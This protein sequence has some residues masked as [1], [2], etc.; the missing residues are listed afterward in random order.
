M[1]H[2]DLASH[3]R[4]AAPI[5]QVWDR[6]ADP[7]GWPRWW[8]GM[9][10]VQTLRPP[11]AQGLGGRHRVEWAG[12]WPR[13]AAVEIEAIESLPFQRLRGRTRGALAGE[14]IW[15]LRAHGHVTEVTGLWR[16]EWINP[17]LR[18][19]APLLAHLVRWNH[20]GLMRAGAQ[21]LARHLRVAEVIQ[22]AFICPGSIRR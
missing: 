9:R 7:P 21:G 18:A 17:W 20:A 22:P 2:L 15:L 10:A 8:P 13:Q 16:V 5:D 11:D 3:W 1:R 6:L 4:I 14:G 19:L 12:R